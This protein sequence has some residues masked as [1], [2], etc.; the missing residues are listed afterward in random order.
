MEDKE[1]TK[2]Q[3]TNARRAARTPE[4]IHNDRIKIH[5]ESTRKKC[6]NCNKMKSL[7]DGFTVDKYKADGLS[8][9][10]R[11]CWQVKRYGRVGDN[12]DNGVNG[13]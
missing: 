6:P 3:K 9:W 5:G 12:G 1:L 2:S 7:R 4:Q 10:C 8:T 11:E 13:E